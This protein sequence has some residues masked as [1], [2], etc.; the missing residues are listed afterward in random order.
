MILWFAGMAVVAVWIVFRDPAIDL[1]LIVGGALL[2]DV[3]DGALSLAGVAGPWPA[4]TL[5]ANAGLLV[6]VML[7]TRGRRLLR[8]RLLALPIGSLLHLVLDGAWTDTTVF[9]WPA[10]G[11]GVGD[12]ALLSVERGVVN[13]V[14]EL[15]GLAALAGV[16]T[17]FHLAEPQRRR[18]LLRTGRV[19]RDLSG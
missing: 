16:W 5:L 8:R 10:L 15:A 11:T 12:Q 13:L 18:Q 2:P 6:G 4:H 7:A 17:R 3:V 9:W 19:G 14:L 1:R